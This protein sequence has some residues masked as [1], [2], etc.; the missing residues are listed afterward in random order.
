MHAVLCANCDSCARV[1]VRAA[2]PSV[3]E[4][5]KYNGEVIA[6]EGSLTD[7]LW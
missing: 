3:D 7:A 2:S 5:G 4:D 6:V 1:R